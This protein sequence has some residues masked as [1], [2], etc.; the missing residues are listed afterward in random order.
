MAMNSYMWPTDR[1]TYK[2]RPPTMNLV[3]G[4]DKYQHILESLNH[5]KIN[6][7]RPPNSDQYRLW[8]SYMGGSSENMNWGSH[9][10]NQ[11]EEVNYLRNRGR[12]P[13]SNTY[14]LEW[15]D[16]PNLKYGGNQ[17]G[18]FNQRVSNFSQ[19]KQVPPFNHLI[20]PNPNNMIGNLRSIVSY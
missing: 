4:K 5:Q 15:C 3:N 13:H 8:G 16:H 2:L 19:T 1:F 14:N 12:N 17:G 18:S 9:L 20:F 7:N 11:Y 10:E 6:S